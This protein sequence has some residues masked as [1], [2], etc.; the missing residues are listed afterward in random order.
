MRL[1]FIASLD[2]LEVKRDSKI[3][4]RTGNGP[5]FLAGFIVVLLS[6]LPL[7]EVPEV[8]AKELPWLEEEETTAATA[9]VFVIISGVIF[10]V[11]LR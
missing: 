11:M 3:D 9:A 2:C 7:L 6:L 10:T 4:R 5:S 1:L 8:S